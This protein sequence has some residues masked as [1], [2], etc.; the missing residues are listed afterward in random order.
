VEGAGG[1]GGVGG[2]EGVCWAFEIVFSLSSSL[3]SS[4]K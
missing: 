1:A 2:V 3:F 4:A